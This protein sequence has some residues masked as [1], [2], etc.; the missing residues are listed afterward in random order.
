MSVG[1]LAAKQGGCLKADERECL[2]EPR[3]LRSA[4][5]PMDVCQPCEFDGQRGDAVRAASREDRCSQLRGIEGI[6]RRVVGDGRHGDQPEYTFRPSS[7]TNV[8]VSVALFKL[9]KAKPL[10]TRPWYKRST[11]GVFS[12][13]ST[14]G[15]SS[16]P[17]GAPQGTA[18]WPQQR[19]R[20]FAC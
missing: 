17:C 11:T 15:F 9:S 2:P 8:S 1:L 14:A 19:P 16:S 13:Q 12:Y 5:F 7:L 4:V 20:M 18:P 10:C 3:K 6:A